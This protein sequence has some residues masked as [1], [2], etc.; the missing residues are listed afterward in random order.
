MPKI[1]IE[2]MADISANS[3]YIP[4]GNFPSD[5]QFAS[6]DLRVAKKEPRWMNEE[7]CR[8]D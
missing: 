5:L 2:I 3:R 6:D 1:S 7:D 4:D 8:A